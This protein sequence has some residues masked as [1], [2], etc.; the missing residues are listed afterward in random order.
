MLEAQRVGA[1]DIDV[2]E[3]GEK[4]GDAVGEAKPLGRALSGGQPPIVV[5]L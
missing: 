3:R 2:D 5:S 4:A 1:D